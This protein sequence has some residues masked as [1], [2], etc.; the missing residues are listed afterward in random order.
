M[1]AYTLT[2]S[3]SVSQN[4]ESIPCG[5][6]SMNPPPPLF[7]MSKNQLV[8]IP[9]KNIGGF[10]YSEIVYMYSSFPISP[11][12]IIS[13]AFCSGWVNLGLKGTISLTP[14]FLAAF[15]ISLPSSSVSAMGFS[16]SISFPSSAALIATSLC[17]Y[18]SIAM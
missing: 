14:A 15:T 10:T 13:L 1:S 11:L 16:R 6:V 7:L 12:S 18:V 5:A 17:L 3:L 4:S 2:G 9:S 8:S